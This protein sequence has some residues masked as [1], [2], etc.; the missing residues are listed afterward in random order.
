MIKG[1]IAPFLFAYFKKNMKYV[2][3]KKTWDVRK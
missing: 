3:N 2:I 1:A